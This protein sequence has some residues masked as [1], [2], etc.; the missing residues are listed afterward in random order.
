[1]RSLGTTDVT[2]IAVGQKY[3]ERGLLSKFSKTYSTQKTNRSCTQ[4]SGCCHGQHYKISTRGPRVGTL[5][6]IHEHVPMPGK[7]RTFTAVTCSPKSKFLL[8][9][10]K[11]L[12]AVPAF[13]AH[14]WQSA[15]QL[16]GG[17]SGHADVWSLALM[18]RAVSKLP[19]QDSVG[20]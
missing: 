19:M 2:V 4:S 20:E 6:G 15:F 13:P 5:M 12:R 16:E 9:L 14:S 11:K 7:G 18:R 8:L 17:C 3:Q 1:M 10:Q